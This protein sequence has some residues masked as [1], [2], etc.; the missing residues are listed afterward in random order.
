LPGI[1]IAGGV[2]VKQALLMAAI[3]RRVLMIGGALKVKSW[4]RLAEIGQFDP[5]YLHLRKPP[6]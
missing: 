6:L 3:F 2:T 5:D 1:S 4:R